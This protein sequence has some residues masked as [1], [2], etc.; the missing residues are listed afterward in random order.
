[1]MGQQRAKFLPAHERLLATSVLPTGEVTKVRFDEGVAFGRSS[2]V[3]SQHSFADDGTQQAEAIRQTT[4]NFEQHQHD[5]PIYIV[6][7]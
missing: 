2:G 4:G 1:M 7:E 5:V 6:N 3:S